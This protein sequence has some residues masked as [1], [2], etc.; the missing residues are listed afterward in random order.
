MG[1]AVLFS[2]TSRDP[3]PEARNKFKYRNSDHGSHR[4]LR[5]LADIDPRVSVMIRAIRGFDFS[6]F[7][8]LTP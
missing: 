1:T 7:V 6:D 5:I 8:L 4:S 2:L 3:K